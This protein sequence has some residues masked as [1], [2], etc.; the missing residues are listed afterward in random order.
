M[1]AKYK[2]TKTFS[3]TK[4]RTGGDKA[5]RIDELVDLFTWPKKASWVRVRLVGPV[6]SYAHHWINITT[7]DGNEI[8]VPKQCL[9]YDAEEETRDSTKK[10]PYCAFDKEQAKFQSY[11]YTNAIIRDLQDD[12]PAKKRIT[13]EEEKTGIKDMDSESWTP[14]RVLRIPPGLAAKLQSLSE[15]NKHGPKDNKKAFPLSHEKYGMDISLRYDSKAAG[16]DKYQVQKEERTALTDEEQEFLMYNIEDLISP[17]ELSVAKAEYKQLAAKVTGAPKEEESEDEDDEEDYE[18]E[19]EEDEPP[20]KSKKP[21]KGKKKP[22]DEDEDEEEEE[23]SEEEED[24]EDEP[25]AKSKKP[26]KKPA[27]SKKSSDE[28]EDD[29]ESDDDVDES[30]EEEDD[31]P[32]TKSKK[33]ALVKPTKGKKKPV[34]EDEDEDEDEEEDEDEDEEEES[35]EEDDED[36]D[37]DDEEEESDEE[38]EEDEPPAKSKKPVKK[39]R[40]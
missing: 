17:E 6:T 13:K 21:T 2:S 22:V 35:D 12:E 39:V 31:E 27:K 34:D 9:S 37:F 7:K 26:V 24:E 8:Q 15:L 20:A 36:F 5:P 16:A 28:E 18:D 33:K 40:K 38:D 32:P 4:A 3:D 14:V 1:K 30:D 11:Y 10:C 19:E 29:D 23:E 25:P